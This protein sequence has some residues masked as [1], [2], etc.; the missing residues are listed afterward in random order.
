ME[1]PKNE[2]EVK[3]IMGFIQ[4]YCIKTPN[5]E[6][7]WFSL[8][9]KSIIQNY[10]RHD[11]SHKSVIMAFERLGYQVE[12]LTWGSTTTEHPINYATTKVFNLEY[13]GYDGD[14]AYSSKD[15]ERIRRK[16]RKNLKV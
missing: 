14:I 5:V 11:V 3:E 2:Q 8:E 10:L 13:V 4:K 15:F 16:E 9:I 12:D 7:R 1:V 6:L